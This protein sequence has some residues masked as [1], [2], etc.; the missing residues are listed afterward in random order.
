LRFEALN[1]D[2]EWDQFIEQFWLRRGTEFKTEHYRSFAYARFAA[3][4]M[5]R[6]FE[7]QAYP[8]GMRIRFVDTHRDGVYRQ[9]P[10]RG[11]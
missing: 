10:E 1:T 8:S 6:R 11:R 7:I 3:S 9:T 2:A 4:S 5:V